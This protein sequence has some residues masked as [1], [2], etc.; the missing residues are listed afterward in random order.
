[1]DD[2]DNEIKLCRLF[3]LED[4][5]CV[6]TLA[7]GTSGSI[8]VTHCNSK[9]ET[10]IDFD[11]YKHFVEE[12]EDGSLVC[13]LWSKPEYTSTSI[14]LPAIVFVMLCVLLFIMIYQNL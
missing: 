8:N 9:L 5:S 11:L 3:L 14:I 12:Q 4:G 2:K 7:S 13:K 1:M 10:P 6:D